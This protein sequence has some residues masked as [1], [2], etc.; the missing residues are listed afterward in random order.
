MHSLFP[1][2]AA[3]P[4]RDT[5]LNA[6]IRALEAVK[7]MEEENSAT[8]ASL[9]DGLAAT[10]A[11][12]V[13]LLDAETHFTYRQLAALA[14]RIARWSLS[15]GIPAHASVCLLM[16][17]RPEYVALWLGLTRAGHV[18]ALLNTNLTGEALAHGIRA[19]DARYLIV[20]ASLS[21]G[22]AVLAGRLPPDARILVWGE[23]GA[24]PSWPRLEPELDHHTGTPLPAAEQPFPD[25]GETALLV[26]TSGTT[27]LPKAARVTH[28]RVLEWSLWFA[29]M[30][31]ARPEDRLYD[32]L[33]LYH[34]T[35]GIVAI[36]AMLVRGGSVLIARRFSARRFWDEVADGGC[37]IFQY[38]GELCR[39]LTVAPAHPRERAHQLRL[40]CGNGLRGEV[41]E[42]FQARFAI[43]RVLEFYA[44]TEGN[45][46]LYNCEGKPG[47]IGR[48]PPFLARRFPVA[49]IRC[50]PETGVPDRDAAGFCIRCEPDETGEAIGRV[51]P[52]PGAPARRF[53]GYTD[54]E[55][56]A[57]KLLSGVFSPG[58]RWFRTGDL[59]RRDMAGFFYFV[60][61]LGD[62][63]RW[64]GE[65]VSTTEVETVLRACPGV[66]D[67]VVYGVAVPGHEGRACMAALTVGEGFDLAVLCA[68]AA[69][70]LPDYARPV[71]ARVCRS[72]AMTGTFKLTKTPLA[73]Q[74]WDTTEDAVW[75]NDRAAGGF[76]PV[77]AALM[78][79]LGRGERRP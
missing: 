19:A 79:A 77:D 1:P 43:P 68:H 37:T 3:Q 32:C 15:G 9:L 44:A 64:K 34:S 5:P 27:G 70:S 48:V 58:D 31:D 30:M 63:F 6:W 25:P 20:D 13:A 59:M 38:I 42:A 10:H 46:S 4:A 40:A 53:D 41:W 12:R 72:L 55:A 74:G 2:A 65:N 69:A 26:Y 66:T 51:D 62:T 47:A 50:D 49:L 8:L 22:V 73:R 16:P 61:R 71:F 7:R 36:G 23:G 45:V 75:F 11:D 21:A 14:N 78:E 28:G 52:G 67:A 24:V 54:A 18:V 29:G 33:P 60:D 56:S 39:Y 35:G 57:R 17:N 76:V